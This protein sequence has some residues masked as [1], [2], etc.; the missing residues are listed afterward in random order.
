[1]APYSISLVRIGA[2]A[3]LSV[4][5]NGHAIHEEQLSLGPIRG[6]WTR[7]MD[8][9]RDIQADHRIKAEHAPVLIDPNWKEATK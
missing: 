9:V 5:Y 2:L 4:W 6:R 8:R 7:L 1:M 3:D